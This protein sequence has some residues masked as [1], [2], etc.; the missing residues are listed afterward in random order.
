MASA[1]RKEGR[2]EAGA[3]WRRRPRRPQCGSSEEPSHRLIRGSPRAIAT[4]G[5]VA[6]ADL[7][8]T[9]RDLSPSVWSRCRVARLFRGGVRT[10][11]GPASED[12][13]YMPLG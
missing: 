1:L 2:P 13:G 12:A 11:K 7:W 6:A 8:S 4:R 3:T 10:E 9:L 5:V